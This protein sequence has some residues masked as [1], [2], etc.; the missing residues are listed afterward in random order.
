M[1]MLQKS[2]QIIINRQK[3]TPKSPKIHLGDRLWPRSRCGPSNVWGTPTAAPLWA[4]IAASCAGSEA[5][6][7]RVTMALGMGVNMRFSD[8]W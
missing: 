7:R 4:R 6:I 5:I 3:S 2:S 8:H 1:H